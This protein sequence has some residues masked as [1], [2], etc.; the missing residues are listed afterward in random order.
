MRLLLASAPALGHQGHGT[1]RAK[2]AQQE[3]QGTGQAPELQ[4]LHAGLVRNRGPEGI[5]EG[6]GQH[7]VALEPH[8]SR[9]PTG[10]FHGEDEGPRLEVRAMAREV[11]GVP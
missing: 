4:P 2:E 11:P 1:A 5:A 9:L 8:L 3:T 6:A 10:L 7:G